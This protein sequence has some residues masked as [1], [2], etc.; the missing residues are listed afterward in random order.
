MKT[1]ERPQCPLSGI[2]IVSIEHMSGLSIIELEQL[3]FCLVRQ[4]VFT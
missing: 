4:G 3:N 1:P 2:F